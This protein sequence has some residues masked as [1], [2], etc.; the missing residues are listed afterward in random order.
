[1]MQEPSADTNVTIMVLSD[2][3]GLALGPPKIERVADDE[4]SVTFR[5][6]RPTWPVR[7]SGSN[8]DWAPLPC[9]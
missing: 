8:S 7:R 3:I 4:D 2:E 1:M 6:S 9:A 5:Y